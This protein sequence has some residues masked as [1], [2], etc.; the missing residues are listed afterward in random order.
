MASV[1]LPA[2]GQTITDVDEIRAFLKPHGIWYEKWD[3]EGRVGE[4]ATDAE[5]LAVYEPEIDRLKQEGGFE[6]ADLI[7]VTPDTPNLEMLSEKFSKE[8]THS[9]DEVRFVVRGRGLFHVNPVEG[10][11]FAIEVSSGDLIN[12]PK[13]TR[14]WFDFCEDRTI[15]CIRLFE[16]KSGWTP[17]Y[18]DDGVHENYAPLCMGP[19]YF[20]AKPSVD[21]V[22]K[23]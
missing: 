14:H 6:T 4:N 22:I 3:V 11:V 10:S 13:G 2:E 20:P 9:E 15:R 12:V 7:N 23:L 17:H 21:P 16:D 18:V 8:H 5:I 1:R 19:D